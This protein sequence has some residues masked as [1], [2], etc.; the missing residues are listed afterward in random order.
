MNCK[1]RLKVT[2]WRIFEDNGG[3]HVGKNCIDLPNRIRPWPL[4]MQ[5]VCLEKDE[6]A[7]FLR[8][9][10]VCLFIDRQRCHSHLKNWCSC[11]KYYCMTPIKCAWKRY[12]LLNVSSMCK[13]NYFIAS[14][15]HFVNQ[16]RKYGSCQKDSWHSKNNSF[17]KGWHSR[18]SIFF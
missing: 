2:F 3:I 9:G 14:S 12:L 10:A 17:L 15:Q 16:V 11:E 7:S 8:S 1:Q 13:I 5:Y 18:Q 4:S 6:N